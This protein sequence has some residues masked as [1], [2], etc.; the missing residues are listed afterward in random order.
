MFRDPL[1]GKNY[2]SRE[3]LRAAQMSRTRSLSSLQSIKAKQDERRRKRQ[4]QIDEEWAGIEVNTSVI[5]DGATSRELS[6]AT[7]TSNGQIH[8]DGLIV[9]LENGRARV[10]VHFL[11]ARTLKGTSTT[12]VWVD[13]GNVEPLGHPFTWW[14]KSNLR[15][16]AYRRAANHGRHDGWDGVG[17]TTFWESRH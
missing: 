17:E 11:E 2:L 12:D 13:R 16:S 9:A 7:A 1:T 8:L 3:E 10:R 4:Q 15:K 6:I 14:M 5:L